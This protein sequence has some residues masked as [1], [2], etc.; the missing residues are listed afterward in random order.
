MPVRWAARRRGLLAR[1]F[2]ARPGVRIVATV[3]AF[4]GA[5]A[6]WQFHKARQ[7]AEYSAIASLASQAEGHLERFYCDTGAF[8]PSL[9]RL[10]FDFAA[11][12]GA[13]AQTLSKLIYESDGQSY[14]LGFDDPSGDRLGRTWSPPTKC[15]NTGS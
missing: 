9:D 6:Y 13:T 15:S 11:T 12:D 8:P 7:Y 14:Y 10:P 4:L 1:G 3:V 5:F 2:T